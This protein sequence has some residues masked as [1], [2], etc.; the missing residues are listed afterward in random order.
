MPVQVA[1]AVSVIP[2]SSTLVGFMS[3]LGVFSSKPIWSSVYLTA[4]L[5]ECLGTVALIPR[6][7]TR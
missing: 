1:S 7:G 4:R 5:S 2:E 6:G 3:G